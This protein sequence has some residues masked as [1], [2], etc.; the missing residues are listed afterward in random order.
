VA[1]LVVDTNVLV[2]AALKP[3]ST[4]GKII[5]IVQRRYELAFTRESFAEFQVTLSQSKFD[6]VLSNRARQRYVAEIR[7]LSQLF[8]IEGSG[9]LSRD[10]RDDIFLHL[11]SAVGVV[12]VVTG[13]R[14]LLV[15]GAFAGIPILSPSRFLRAERSIRRGRQT[16]G[17]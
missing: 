11:A 16:R 14:D 6:A 12:A 17:D 7:R 3:K 4:A 5:D 13:D 9:P 8:R 1:F 2:S 15:L 10:P